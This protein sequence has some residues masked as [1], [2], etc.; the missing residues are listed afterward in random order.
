[1]KAM[2]L[3]RWAAM[4]LSVLLAVSS[5]AAATSPWEQP[6]AALA[7]Q[8]AGI[9][10]PGQ[11]HLSIRNVSRISSE[12]V[13]AIRKLLEQDLKMHGVTVSDD[14]SA[15]SIRVTLSENAR[16]RLWVAEVVEGSVTQVAMVQLSPDGEQRAQAV[17]GLTLRT[18]R[19]LTSREPVLAALETANGLVVLETEQIVFE[20]RGPD[21]WHEQS[22][23][24]IGQRR[25]LP[26]DP[27]GVLIPDGGAQFEAWLA[28]TQCRGSYDP[29]PSQGQWMVSCYASDDPWPLTQSDQTAVPVKAFFNGARNY[30]TGVITPSVGADPPPFYSTA[31]IPRASGGTA[32]VV[33]GI[34]GK[35]LTIENGVLK[36]IAGTRD[37]G[38]DFAAIHSGCGTGTQIVASSSGE[39]AVDSL[40]AY[41][42][43]A[44]E[45]IP[46]SAPL[47]VRGTV[48]ALWPAPDGKTVLAATR[49]AENQYEVDRVS[50]L[51]N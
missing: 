30:F 16:A 13:P 48:V 2:K 31:W 20:T 35:V 39:A 38:S 15:N 6:A 3:I 33:G 44:L 7:E 5:S 36:P 21:G 27:K 26:R 42:F 47:D 28:G 43:P 19:V 51:C 17:G 49:G 1:M 34:D 8:I 46:V 11:A 10:G 37:W 24:S 45:A 32:L 18:E 40:L 12:D 41:E 9:L 14:E 23:V 4:G 50:A 22:R 25:P 29:A